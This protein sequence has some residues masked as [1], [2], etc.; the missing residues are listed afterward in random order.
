MIKTE[1]WKRNEKKRNDHSRS[2]QSVWST[3]RMSVRASN[4]LTEC[5]SNSHRRKQHTHIILLWQTILFTQVPLTPSTR[6]DSSVAL[7][8][9]NDLHGNPSHLY[10]RQKNQNENNKST[11]R[12]NGWRRSA[13]R[14]VYTC[15]HTV[16][17]Y[18]YSL[19]T[20]CTAV[21]LLFMFIHSSHS[22][23][24]VMMRLFKWIFI[25]FQFRTQDDCLQL[26]TIRCI[27]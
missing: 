27:T 26:Q 23:D 5:V 19:Q 20:L 6:Y 14:L 4:W 25:N 18:N 15:I 10:Q 9:T 22:I 3:Y 17:D 2:R 21:R 1:Q 7:H 8:A 13:H 12:M 24:G 16:C 11:N